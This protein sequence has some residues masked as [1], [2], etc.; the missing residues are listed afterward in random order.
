MKLSG[1]L[2]LIIVVL[3]SWFTKAQ[4]PPESPF[5]HDLAWSP[6]GQTIAIA[7][8]NGVWLY[9][10]QLQTLPPLSTE[11]A[12]SLAYNEDGSLLAV[13]YG[14]NNITIYQNQTELITWQTAAPDPALPCEVVSLSFSLES[15]STYLVASTQ[16]HGT[17][18]YNVDSSTPEWQLDEGNTV[19]V[20]RF[21]VG[22][23]EIA[24]GN[25]EQTVDLKDTLSSQT[26]T[27]WDLNTLN[28]PSILDMAFSPDGAFLL[29]GGNSTWVIA[30]DVY[31]GEAGYLWDVLGTEVVEVDWSFD[32]EMIGVANYNPTQPDESVVQLFKAEYNGAE[33]MQLRGHT[34]KILGF[35]FHPMAMQA[36]TI[37]AD[38][39]IR[40]W[41]TVTGQELLNVPYTN[42]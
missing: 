13:G 34:D 40:L 14:Q 18:L 5:I 23:K 22:G 27:D 15:K 31:T 6:D 1:L 32:G 24:F 17:A 12:F 38:N 8:D 20:I 10:A 26:I 42:S 21:A 37:S 39:S 16:N 30:L 2:S 41:D 4:I 25:I 3:V 29:L 19:N 9:D 35:A 28:I 36:V 33:L 7:T 11:T